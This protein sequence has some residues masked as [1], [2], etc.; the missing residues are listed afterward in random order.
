MAHSSPE[1]LAGFTIRE[2]LGSGAYAE[3]WR[4]IGQNGQD[5]ALKYFQGTSKPEIAQNATNEARILNRLSHPNIIKCFG[6]HETKTCL[7]L[8]QELAR[9]QTLSDIISKRVQLDERLITT[10]IRR[11]ASALSYLENENVI[12]YDI[13]PSNIMIDGDFRANPEGI[14]VKLIDFGLSQ[15]LASSNLTDIFSSGTKEYAAPEVMYDSLCSF[16]LDDRRCL[17]SL[18]RN[19]SPR[20]RFVRVF[21]RPA[22]NFLLLKIYESDSEDIMRT[23]RE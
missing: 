16:P 15:D 13:K 6:L 22:M 11:V 4:A 17:S 14:I 20:G 19:G 3:V 9:G 7:V 21:D 12:H 1:P 2:R 10:V 23:K 8:V 18:Q 5:Y